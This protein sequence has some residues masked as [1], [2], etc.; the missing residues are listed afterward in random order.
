MIA[1]LVFSVMLASVLLYAW[2]EY[3]RSPAIAMLALLAGFAGLY[4]VWRPADS[5]SLA[6]FVGIGRGADLVLYIWVCISLIIVLN[7][8]LKLRTQHELITMLA[9]SVALASFTRPEPADD[10]SGGELAGK[11]A[12]EDKDDATSLSASK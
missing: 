12:Y 11:K 3:R 8:H 1:Q 2:R 6:E 10:P 9:R 7:L 5:T 4:F